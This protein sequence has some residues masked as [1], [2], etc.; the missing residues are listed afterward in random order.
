MSDKDLDTQ[1]LK[2]L[3]SVSQGASL[4]LIGKAISNGLGFFTNLILTRILGASLYGI[5]SYVIVVFSLIQVFTRLGGDQSILRFIPEYQDNR[6]KQYTVLTLAYLTSAIASVI[7]A[8]LVY[9][10]APL[11]SNYTLQDPLFVD[12]LRISSIIIPFNTLSNITYSIFKGIER[13]DYNVVSSSIAQP[14]LRLVFVGG[15]VLLGYSLVGAV[16]G[17]VISAILT[18]I[19][20]V[21]ILFK[22]THFTTFQYPSRHEALDYYDFSVPLTFTQIGSFMYNRVDIL[23]VGFFLTGSAVGIYN[24]TVMLA[25]FLAL[26]LQAFNQLF[27]PIASKLYHNNQIKE[28]NSTY[29]TITRWTFSLSL[30]PAII[31]IVYSNEILYI[32]GEEFI[33]GKMVLILFVSAQFTYCA[34]GPSGYLLMMSDHQYLTLFNQVS[35]GILNIVLNYVLILEF[36]LIGAA[37]A[38]AS[39]LSGINI[40]RIFE[41]WY[42]EDITPYSW[43]FIYPLIAGGIS[44]LGLYSVTYIF[45][46]YTLI[47]M[48]SVIGC[49]LY[50]STIY[51]FGLQEEEIKTFQSLMRNLSE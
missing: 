50:F 25:G 33:E 3:G 23:M 49:C 11:I 32:F 51:I 40:L 9:Y 45:D 27:P 37:L 38:T 26:P 8:A 41:I 4:F 39:V 17:L 22:K 12:I 16:A 21:V 28:L 19:F 35:S 2:S 14:F 15:G 29:T 44:T 36:G 42:L 18:L 30:L 1:G 13:M 24:I 47:F 34:V 5:Y 10:F 46:G 6:R 7:A 43:S 20:S 48:G 31:S